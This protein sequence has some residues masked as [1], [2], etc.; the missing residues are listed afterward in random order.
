MNK[1]T[2]SEVGAVASSDAIT[3]AEIDDICTWDKD[4]IVEER[5]ES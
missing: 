2:A 1:P 5:P 3:D 4:F